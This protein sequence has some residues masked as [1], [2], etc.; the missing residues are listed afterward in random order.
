MSKTIQEI[1]DLK[2][3]WLEDPCW[4]IEDSDGFEEHKEELLKYRLE[5]E[6]IWENKRLKKEKEIDEKA[7]E[8]GIE[9]LYR[10]LI[11]HD[12]L[13]ERHGKA[14]DLLAD[15]ES[16]RTYRVLRGYED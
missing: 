3:D 9:G 5:Q 11:K 14:I 7:R 12:E 2:K 4:D 15:G 8:L 13:L 16:H 10:M 1:E 6:K